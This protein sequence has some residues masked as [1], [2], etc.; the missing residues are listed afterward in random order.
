MLE[1]AIQ[2]LI[3]MQQTQHIFLYHHKLSHIR[4]CTLACHIHIDK[5]ILS[6]ILWLCAAPASVFRL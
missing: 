6:T 5:S 3:G 2:P 4:T 1:M